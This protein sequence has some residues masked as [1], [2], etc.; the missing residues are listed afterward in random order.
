[1]LFPYLRELM[2]KDAGQLIIIFGF[3]AINWLGYFKTSLR[4]GD[5][6]QF[7]FPDASPKKVELKE[8]DRMRTSDN[9]SAISKKRDKFFRRFARRRPFDHDVRKIGTFTQFSVSIPGDNP[10]TYTRW[11]KMVSLRGKTI[12]MYH[13]TYDRTGSFIHRGV[14]VPRPEKHVT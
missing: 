3:P 4:D 8:L 12:R 5:M 1:M 2:R 7:G 10:G 13:D 9:E 11:V 14:K 6:R